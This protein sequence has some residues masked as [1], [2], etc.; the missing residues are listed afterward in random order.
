MQRTSPGKII[1]D[2]EASVG[3]GGEEEE[4]EGHAQRGCF[5]HE[6]RKRR[7]DGIAGG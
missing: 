2:G 7:G 4:R 5:Q 6:E 3:G 1:V